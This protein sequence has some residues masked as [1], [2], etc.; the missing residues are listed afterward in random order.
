M[1]NRRFGTRC[2]ASRRRM[3]GSEKLLGSQEAFEPGKRF[4]DVDYDQIGL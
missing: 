2:K 3:P 1:V 4:G